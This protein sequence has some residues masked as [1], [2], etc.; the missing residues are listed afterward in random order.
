MKTDAVQIEVLS[1]LSPKSIVGCIAGSGVYRFE[2][3][4]R[5]SALQDVQHSSPVRPTSACIPSMQ[6]DLRKGAYLCTELVT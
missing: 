1:V 5:I 4:K 6:W 2:F 3:K